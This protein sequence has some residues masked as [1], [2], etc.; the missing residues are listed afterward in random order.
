MQY[1]LD[2]SSPVELSISI[3][4]ESIEVDAAFRK[5]PNDPRKTL[6]DTLLSSILEKEHIDPISSPA[7]EGPELIPGNAYSFSVRFSVLPPIDIPEFSTL[8]IRVPRPDMEPEELRQLFWACSAVT[9][10]SCL[11]PSP[12]SQRPARSFPLI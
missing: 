8:E 6:A 3:Q 7:Y 2:R 5:D 9:R 11:S 12:A 1:T 10:N 4:A